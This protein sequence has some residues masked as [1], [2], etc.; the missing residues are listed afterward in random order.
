MKR[1]YTLDCI[2]TKLQET[3][4]TMIHSIV[5]FMNPRKKPRLLL[6]S[7]FRWLFSALQNGINDIV[8]EPA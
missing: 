3:S 5:L 8:P 6:R 7:F 1:R 4:K 2:V